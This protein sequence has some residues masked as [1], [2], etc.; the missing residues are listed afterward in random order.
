MGL[1]LNIQTISRGK[2]PFDNE[3]DTVIMS[4]AFTGSAP[5]VNGAIWGA[6][7]KR[8][9]YS[10]FDSIRL[11]YRSHLE[12]TLLASPGTLG[13][14]RRKGGRKL[15]IKLTGEDLP[16]T[17]NVTDRLVVPARLLATQVYSPA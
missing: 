8:V 3:Q 16:L 12:E 10:S 7:G 15:G 13:G 5:K 1:F 14:K 4:P 11:L 2:S 9:L 17:A 6:T